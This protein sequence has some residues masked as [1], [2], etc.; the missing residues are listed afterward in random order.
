MKIALIQMDIAFGNPDKNR[1]YIKQ[2]V[3]EAMSQYNIDVFVL[4]ELWTTGYDLARFDHIAERYGET[5]LPF[6][7]ELAQKHDVHFIAGSIANK[8]EDGFYNTFVVV[9]RKGEVVKQYDKA[10]LFR[11]MEEEKFL[12]QGNDDGNFTLSDQPSAGVICYDIRF[13]EWI[14]ALMLDG[15]KVVY[16]VA[17]WPKPRIDHW[18]T[19][20]MSRAIENQCFVVACNRVGEDPNNVFGGHSMVIGPWGEVL[21]EADDQET[22]VIAD[23]DFSEVDQVRERIPVYHDRRTDLYRFK[24]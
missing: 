3:E 13:P 15:A 7:A 12:Q 8:K 4:P 9:N 14:R 1:D 20:L 22:T 21:A 11:L 18:R 16:V 19:L 17:E 10:H 2:R 23:I 5:T 6:I 24:S